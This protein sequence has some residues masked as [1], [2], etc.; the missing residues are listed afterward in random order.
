M[1][2]L[3]LF[4]GFSVGFDFFC[5]SLGVVV[6]VFVWEFGLGVCFCLEVCNSLGFCIHF[7]AG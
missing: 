2:G 7:G 1:W 3:Y 4:R 5:I 6:S